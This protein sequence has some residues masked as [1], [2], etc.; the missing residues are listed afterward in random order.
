MEPGTY[1]IKEGKATVAYVSV[2]STGATLTPNGLRG[3]AL[4]ELQEAVGQ[5]LLPDGLTAKAMDDPSGFI[6]PRP[7]WKELTPSATKRLR[8]LKARGKV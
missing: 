7:N 3:D 1:A 4:T 6:R 5:G 8:W 2:T